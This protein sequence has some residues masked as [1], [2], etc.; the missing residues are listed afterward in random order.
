GIGQHMLAF[1]EDYGRAEQVSALRLDVYEKNIPAICLYER[2][3]YRY[4][5]TVSLGLEAYGLN[6]FRLYEKLL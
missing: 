1:A 2:A 6:G 5:D 4:I 3:G